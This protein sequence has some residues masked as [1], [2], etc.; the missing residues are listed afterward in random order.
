M[1][2][3]IFHRSNLHSTICKCLLQPYNNLIYMLTYVNIYYILTYTCKYLLLSFTDC[4]YIFQLFAFTFFYSSISF[5]FSFV[6]QIV[7]FHILNWEGVVSNEFLNVETIQLIFAT[8]TTPHTHTLK[9]RKK[10]RTQCTSIE[11]IIIEI[12]FC[13][14]GTVVN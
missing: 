1:S 13:N 7:I 3:T 11:I 12:K 2:I 14:V 10:D 4:I 6:N 9:K 8:S 5:S